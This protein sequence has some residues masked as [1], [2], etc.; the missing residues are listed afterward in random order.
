MHPLRL[1]MPIITNC[2]RH[3]FRIQARIRELLRARP[4]FMDTL[5]SRPGRLPCLL[6]LIGVWVALLLGHSGAERIMRHHLSLSLSVRPSNRAATENE[7]SQRSR[8]S[9]AARFVSCKPTCLAMCVDV[10]WDCCVAPASCSSHESTCRWCCCCAIEPPH[11]K[12]QTRGTVLLLPSCEWE[13]D[14][15]TSQSWRRIELSSG[16][17]GFLEK[18]IGS[19]GWS[20]GHARISLWINYGWAGSA[21]IE[22]AQGK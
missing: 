14:T 1:S 15:T 21:A 11:N 3:S 8:Q 17:R 6:A 5:R 13:D 22:R 4:V 19:D 16:E 7:K 18:L 10:S 20:G 12:I 2:L 9:I